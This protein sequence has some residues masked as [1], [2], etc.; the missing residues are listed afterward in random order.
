MISLLIITNTLKRNDNLHY[1]LLYSMFHNDRQMKLSDSKYNTINPLTKFLSVLLLLLL[2]VNITT[3]M[4]YSCR[5]RESIQFVMI[6][7]VRVK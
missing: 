4:K 6:V 2:K 3:N 5:V 1:P 7:N